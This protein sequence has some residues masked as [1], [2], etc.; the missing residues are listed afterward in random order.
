MQPDPS[1]PS[2]T[3]SLR[4]P[5]LWVVVSIAVVALL[6]LA[7]EAQMHW[8][9]VSAFV[10]AAI[11]R[12]DPRFGASAE[13]EAIASS[14]SI[15]AEIEALGSEHAW[16]GQYS[17]SSA[18]LSL[19]PESG[20][21]Y[22]A[23]GCRGILDRNFGTVTATADHINLV[24]H[25]PSDPGWLATRFV[26]I[27]WGDR[28]YLV[29]SDR[30]EQFCS[31]VNSFWEPRHE[32]RG[33]YFLRDG[34]EQIPALGLPLVPEKYRGAL[35]S[36]PIEA[37]IIQIV[38]SGKGEDGFIHARVRLDAGSEQ[39]VVPHMTMRLVDQD[40]SMLLGVDDVNPKDCSGDVAGEEERWAAPKVGWRFTSRVWQ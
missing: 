40:Q 18:S 6:R 1:K 28:H 36:A 9:A 16:A 32:V 10:R 31:D 17:G 38:S 39:G 23:H 30:M 26:P 11:T 29:P 3:A 22:E 13:S 2:K 34:D 37:K 14:D 25:F 21:V 35:L 7:L 8:E 33:T 12:P 5:L 19:A 15:R 4:R 27:G 24:L 20:F